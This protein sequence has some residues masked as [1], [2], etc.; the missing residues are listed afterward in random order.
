MRATHTVYWPT[1][2]V[3]HVVY[4]HTL[5]RCPASFTYFG[6]G[7]G[8]VLKVWDTIQNRFLHDTCLASMRSSHKNSILIDRFSSRIEYNLFARFLNIIV[9][10]RV[11]E[12]EDYSEDWYAYF[13]TRIHFIYNNFHIMIH[14]D[15]YTYFIVYFNFLNYLLS[16]IS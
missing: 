3:S 4:K 2:S 6:N 11:S 16:V 13:R 1:D 7:N 8:K 5:I 9:W 12:S 10:K 14:V 15:E